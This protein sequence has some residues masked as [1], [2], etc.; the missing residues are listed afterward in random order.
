ML[1]LKLQDTMTT[2]WELT[3]L[4]RPR[5]W[6]RMKAGGEGDDRGWDGWMASPTQCTWIWASSRSWWWTGKPGMLQSM[7]L[8]RVGH[9]WVTELT[10]NGQIQRKDIKETIKIASRRNRK[11]EQIHKKTDL[12]KKKTDLKEKTRPT[13]MAS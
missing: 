9:N 4:K 12:I 5:C 7:R 8:Q 13:Q 10:Y 3:H 2:W 6:E 11:S 1:K